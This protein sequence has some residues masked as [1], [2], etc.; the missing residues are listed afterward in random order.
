[1]VAASRE[2]EMRRIAID[3][4]AVDIVL[5]SHK[6]KQ[7]A[8]RQKTDEALKKYPDEAVLFR[9]RQKKRPGNAEAAGGLK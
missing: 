7:Q 8:V 3:R 1:V 4:L 2:Q 9:D 6:R 5:R